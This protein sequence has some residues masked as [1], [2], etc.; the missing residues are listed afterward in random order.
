MERPRLGNMLVKAKL[1]S[2]DQ[3][4]KALDFQK[5][6]GGKFGAILVKLGFVTDEALT[7]FLAQQ[8]GL[9]IANLANLVI[10]WN[11]VKRVPKSLIEKHHVIPIG[12]KDG[13]LT[14]AVSDPFDYEAIEEIQL[15]T[16]SRI[17]VHLASREQ[18]NKAISD[19]L[20]SGVAM[21]SETAVEEVLKSLEEAD[22][23]AGPV[24][25]TDARLVKVLFSILMDKGI[26]TQKELLD[27]AK[28]IK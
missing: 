6:V 25:A 7:N 24:G 12:Y 18:I 2:E 26:I 10:P 21:D 9:Q 3:F 27:K 11:L 13:I 28:Q 17:E 20:Y 4:K 1:L 5:T 23:K 22:K 16:N 8:Q 19:A 15:A 14:L